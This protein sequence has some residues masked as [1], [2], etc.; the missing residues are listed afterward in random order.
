MSNLDLSIL[1]FCIVLINALADKLYF[2]VRRNW[3]WEWRALT[4]NIYF[5]NVWFQWSFVTSLVKVQYYFEII[6]AYIENYMLM[7]VCVFK[8][9]QY[10]LAEFLEQNLNSYPID[11]TQL[12]NVAAMI[13]MVSNVC[14]SCG[15]CWHFKRVCYSHV[16]PIGFVPT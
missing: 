7:L 5:I 8:G 3:I 6:I 2:I 15:L 16:H 12:E 9:V 4:V 13:A 10:R 14:F 11:C 1:R